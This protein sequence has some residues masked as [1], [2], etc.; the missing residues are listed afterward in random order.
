MRIAAWDIAVK[1]LSV[2]IMDTPEYNKE[3]QLVY[4]DPI[5]WK[6]INL[7][8]EAPKCMD[9][10][11]DIP[12]K[13]KN[14]VNNSYCG[15]HKKR[16]KLIKEMEP[17]IIRKVNEYT[18]Y[19]IQIR[20][21][22]KLDEFPE[23]Y[24]VDYM[25]I[26]NQE[27]K[28]VFMKTIASSIFTYY[29]KKAY[30][31]IENPRLKEIR[32]ISATKKI[33]KVPFLGE[34]YISEKKSNYDK[35]KETSIIYCKRYIKGRK[36]LEDF[37]KSHKRKQDDLADSFMTCIAG[38]WSLHFEQIYSNLTMDQL[39]KIANKHNVSLVNVKG[40]K[41]TKKQLT[42]DLM[43]VWIWINDY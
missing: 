23:I 6:I 17:I 13:W 41:R 28:N 19:E 25:F 22:K 27:E 16:G 15:R 24:D 1:T 26:E 29:T 31:D 42:K 34:K 30:V 40:R 38:I 36:H 33:K 37:F 35:R 10:G 3:N 39:I 32:Y 8:E 43:E 2:C 4:S 14:E 5:C 18:P 12:S 11:C 20:L 9:I 7:L 21:V